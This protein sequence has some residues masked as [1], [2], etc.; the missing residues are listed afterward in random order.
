MYILSC[1]STIYVGG[2]MSSLF[3]GIV[4]VM[5]F[6]FFRAIHYHHKMS[7]IAK[8]RDCEDIDTFTREFGNE[9][10][11]DAVLKFGFRETQK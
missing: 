10:V 6:T 4:A 8:C 1:I 11:D 3:I 7:C 2:C 9:I 5:F